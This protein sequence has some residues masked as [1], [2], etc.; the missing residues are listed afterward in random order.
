MK[1]EKDVAIFMMI[2]M[3]KNKPPEHRLSHVSKSNSYEKAIVF[4]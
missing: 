1:S 3:E 4:C 2:E